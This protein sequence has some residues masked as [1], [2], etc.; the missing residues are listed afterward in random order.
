MLGDLVFRT[1]NN[2]CY[3]VGVYVG[4]GRVVE[5][6]GRD[7]GVILRGIDAEKGYWTH[8]GRLKV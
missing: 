2:D 7:D 5:S 6:K 1:K 8:Y 3:H 4:K